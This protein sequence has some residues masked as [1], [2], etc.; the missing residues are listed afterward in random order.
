MET[1]GKL[2]KTFERR[3]SCYGRLLTMVKYAT[4][5]TLLWIFVGQSCYLLWKFWGNFLAAEVTRDGT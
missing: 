3:T 1:E 5:V 4:D 2:V